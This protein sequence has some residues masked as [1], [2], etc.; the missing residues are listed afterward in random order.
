[1]SEFP[2]YR[3]SPS[4]SAIEHIRAL[5]VRL[6]EPIAAVR[7][8]ERA[9]RLHRHLDP[10]RRRVRRRSRAAPPPDGRSGSLRRCA[11]CGSR[12]GRRG[13]LAAAAQVSRPGRSTSTGPAPPGPPPRGGA[14]ST[15]AIVAGSSMF[16]MNTPGLFCSIPALYDQCSCQMSSSPGDD[17]IVF[18]AST[19]RALARAVL[20][21]RHARLHA[22][23]ERR[24]VRRIEPVMRH[25]E[26]VHR[27]DGIVRAHQL[28]FLVP[29]QIAEIDRAELTE[30]DHAADRL[31]VVIGRRHVFRRDARA[32][33]IRLARRREAASSGPGRRMSRS[34]SRGR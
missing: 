10:V 13:L 2:S 22:V 24:R 34:A 33:G 7:D 14:V 30:G 18:I 19:S 31:S 15:P 29:Q 27:P 28:V 6:A 4:R 32:R 11:W 20:H 25:K 9:V 23:H 21:D 12:R 5:R 3:E 16:A 8:R 1:M 26:H 17:R